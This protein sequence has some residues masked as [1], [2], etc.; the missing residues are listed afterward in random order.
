[1]EG[2]NLILQIIVDIMGISNKTC[3]MEMEFKY[4][5]MDRNIWESII[6]IK[7]MERELMN[8][9]MVENFRELGIVISEREKAYIL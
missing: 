7:S 3:F 1:M 8:G 5:L 4:G 2:D 6:L 9:M